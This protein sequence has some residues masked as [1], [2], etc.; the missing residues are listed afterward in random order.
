MFPDQ[1]SNLQPWHIGMMLKPTE[2]PGK[3][4]HV[5]DMLIFGW[6]EMVVL[7]TNVEELEEMGLGLQE[8]T[9]V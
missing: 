4:L 1:G 7:L 9:C 6:A 2:L 3:G 5:F 8:L